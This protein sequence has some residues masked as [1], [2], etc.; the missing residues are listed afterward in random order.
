MIQ[1]LKHTL[2]LSQ[3]GWKHFLWGCGACFLQAMALMMPGILL[4]IVVLHLYAGSLLQDHLWFYIVATIV[5]VVL[6]FATTWLQYRF[7]F[8]TTYEESG[9]RRI[10]LAEKLRTLPLSY[11]AKKN[12]ADITSTMMVDCT[13]LEQTLSHFLPELVGSIL[14]TI[15]FGIALFFLDWELALAA[16]WVFPVSLGI[17]IASVKLQ[18]HRN[19]AQLAAKMDCADGIQEFLESIR[20]IKANNAEDRYVKRLAKKVAMVEKTAVS[21]EALTQILLAT[22]TW[23]LKL[24]IACVALVGILRLQDH[25]LS[26][27]TF[28]LFLF[29]VARLYD[30]L[31]SVLM[32]L[33]IFLSAKANFA[34]MNAVLHHPVQKG[35]ATLQN[36][37]FDIVFD[38]VCFAYDTKKSVLHDVSFVAKQNE[39]CALIGP[40]GGGKTT[41]SMLAARFWDVT[42]GHIFVGGMDI[43]KVDPETLLS[44]Y[45]IVFQEVT[46]FNTSIM[47]NIR[48]GKKDAS[49]EEVIRAATLA[50]C[51]AFVNQ[52][53]DGWHT[54]IGENGGQLSGGERQ[55]ISIARALLKDAAIILLDEAT[56]SLDVENETLLQ[57]ALTR[58]IAHKTV[59]IIAHRMRTITA[60]DSIVVVQQG[61]IIEQGSPTILSQQ[62]GVYHHMLQLQEETQNWTIA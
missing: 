37:G 13:V 42:S 61:R 20:D 19:G 30:P 36:D 11:F 12:L 41:I 22:T 53:P 47:E 51:D 28:F 34:R 27:M 35:K 38:H 43:S 62:N 10:A 6:I 50:N 31:E 33:M 16:L 52:L 3:Q 5:C 44:L 29:I 24:G 54:V 4:Y 32:N 26:I 18:E 23:V 2:A 57:A 60:A 58:L 46:L 59:L 39:V 1:K 7:T 25:S 56:A 55:R 14:S 8:F 45:S 40:S 9:V 21:S 15:V 49:D 17:V 48:I